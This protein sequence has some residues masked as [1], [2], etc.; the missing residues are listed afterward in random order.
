M[1]LFISLL[2]AGSLLL[3][4]MACKKEK[5]N[6]EP[7]KEKTPVDLLTQ[8]KWI[9]ASYGFDDNNN[10]VVDEQEDMSRDCERDNSH[11]FFPDSTGVAKDNDD[12]QIRGKPVHRR[13]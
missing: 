9:L 10:K 4:A 1:K 7:D 11:E 13:P 2:I 6:K 12:P 8:Q 5:N 3:L